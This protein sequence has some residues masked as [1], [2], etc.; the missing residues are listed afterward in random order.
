VPIYAL[1]FTQKRAQPD[2]PLDERDDIGS[3]AKI[4]DT[5]ILSHQA[6]V[7]ASWICERPAPLDSRGRTKGGPNEMWWHEAGFATT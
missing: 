7:R 4:P 5:G 1:S 2:E 6:S 3:G